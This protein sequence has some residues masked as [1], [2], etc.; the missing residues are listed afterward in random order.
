MIDPFDFF[1]YRYPY[2]TRKDMELLLEKSEIINLKPGDIFFKEGDT[3]RKTGFIMK[4]LLRGYHKED[5]KEEETTVVF[6]PEG[7]P[8]TSYQW[9]RGPSPSRETFEALEPTIIMVNT[10]ERLEE[11]REH[12]INI[13]RLYSHTLEDKLIDTIERIQNFTMRN[14]ETRYL[15]LMKQ[16]PDLM[17]RVPQ[18]YLA[19]YLGITQQSLSRIRARI[20]KK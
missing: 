7:Q 2:L 19:S 14:P 6:I 12:H 8:C 18:K 10:V 15:A 1:K 16:K 4:G 17:Q 13:L 9:L 5:D 3:T 20:S 11:L